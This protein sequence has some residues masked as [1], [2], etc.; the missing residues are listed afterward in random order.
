MDSISQPAQI[1]GEALSVGLELS[2][3]K[4]WNNYLEEITFEE[5]KKELNNF[6][7]NKSFVTGILK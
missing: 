7:Y 2:E 6:K 4:N 3:I 1:V 5:V